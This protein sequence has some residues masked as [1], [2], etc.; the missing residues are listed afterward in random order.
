MDM[1]LKQAAVYL[2]IEA[3]KKVFN[4]PENLS[5]DETMATILKNAPLPLGVN[6]QVLDKAVRIQLSIL[7]FRNLTME[8]WS[9]GPVDL[10]KE[11]VELFKKECI[12]QGVKMEQI[13]PL[14]RCKIFFADRI[15]PD[16]Q[17][18]SA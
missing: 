13:S 7:P 10:P 18:F 9:I 17:S 8:L 2:R 4:F 16:A 11:I 6:I 15:F 1:T 5:L 12:P 3:A 14:G